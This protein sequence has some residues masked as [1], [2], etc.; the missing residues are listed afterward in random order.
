VAEVFGEIARIFSGYWCIE[1]YTGRMSCKSNP[2]GNWLAP[3]IINA[4][5]IQAGI[6]RP[7]RCQ[8]FPEITGEFDPAIRERHPLV[9]RSSHNMGDSVAQSCRTTSPAGL[10]CC[11]GQLLHDKAEIRMRTP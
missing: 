10:D 9:E 11:L 1:D 6:Y 2:P 8:T 5:Q 4:N 3:F 7:A